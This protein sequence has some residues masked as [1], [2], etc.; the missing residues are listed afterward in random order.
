M[1]NMTP[2]YIVH[3]EMLKSAT[4]YCPI[5]CCEKSEKSNQI[6]NIITPVSLIRR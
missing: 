3:K 4:S 2:Y 6:K 5:E 1:I